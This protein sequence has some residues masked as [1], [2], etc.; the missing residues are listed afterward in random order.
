M[1]DEVLLELGISSLIRR[2]VRIAELIEGDVLDASLE[3]GAEPLIYES[4][5]SLDRVGGR[6]RECNEVDRVIADIVETGESCDR[7]SSIVY[8]PLSH[9]VRSK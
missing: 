3:R 1:F 7:L 5:P 4:R 2:P 8:E 9:L 6:I